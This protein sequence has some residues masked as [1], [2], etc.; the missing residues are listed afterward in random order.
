MK[1]G[2]RAPTAQGELE[3]KLNPAWTAIVLIAFFVT[4]GIGWKHPVLGVIVGLI[5]R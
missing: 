2:R 4:A 3:R 5:E 1:I